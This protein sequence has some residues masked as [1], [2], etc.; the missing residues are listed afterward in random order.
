[1]VGRPFSSEREQT[2]PGGL[3]RMIVCVRRGWMCLPPVRTVSV[4]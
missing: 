2:S 1:M 3:W 4:G